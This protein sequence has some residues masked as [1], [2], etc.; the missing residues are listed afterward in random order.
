MATFGVISRFTKTYVHSLYYASGIWFGTVTR[1]TFKVA[2]GH[3]FLEIL[4]IEIGDL[5]IM[6]VKN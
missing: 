3:V 6:T 5:Q 2:G 4:Y 1:R